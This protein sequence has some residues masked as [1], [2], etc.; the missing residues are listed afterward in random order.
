MEHPSS[1]WGDSFNDIF[2]VH[3]KLWRIIEQG[4]NID[5]H[6]NVLQSLHWWEHVGE[7]GTFHVSQIRME[8]ENRDLD[9]QYNKIIDII[10][11]GVRVE[12]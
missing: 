2:S 9:D 7:A 11:R 8:W 10:H 6:G 1:H 12:R 4:I 5:I 3:V